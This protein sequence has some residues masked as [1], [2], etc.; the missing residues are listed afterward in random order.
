MSKRKILKLEGED[1][2]RWGHRPKGTFSTQEAYQLLTQTNPPP[3][4]ELWR[5]IWSLQ[6]WPKVTTFLWLIS[7]SSIL[8]WD[9]LSKRGFLG[10]SICL[11]CESAEETMNHLLNSCSYTAQLWD[12]VAIIMRKSD[13]RRESV[14]DTIANWRDK[15]F[16]SPLLNRIW[17]LLPGFILW[18]IWKE[19][20]RR[21]FRNL[22]QPWQSCWHNCRTHVL[23]TISLQHWTE[24]Q[25]SSNPSELPILQ[26]WQPFPFPPLSLPS[27]SP[28]TPRAPL[29]GAPHPPLSSNSIS[30]VPQKA[31]QERR[32]T[33]WFFGTTGATFS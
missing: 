15:A 33:E 21:V 25:G 10:P 30:M 28:L 20:N 5:K 18:Q 27:P 14:I 4:N 8:T 3:T 31:I 32:D 19:R 16:L 23:E 13:R 11:L 7:H 29:L 12:Q 9:N 1:I 22:S 17:Q 26:H 2:L 24:D 6:H